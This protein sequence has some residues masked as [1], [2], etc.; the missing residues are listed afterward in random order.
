MNIN[1]IFNDKTYSYLV[2]VGD[3]PIFAVD[4]LGTITHGRVH[5][6]LDPVCVQEALE[7]HSDVELSLIHI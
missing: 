1:F 5:S 3:S 4:E 6:N 2:T 7:H